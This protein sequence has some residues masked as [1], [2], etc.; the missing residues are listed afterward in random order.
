MIRYTLKYAQRRQII[1]VCTCLDVAWSV[2]PSCGCVG[3]ALICITDT[4][5][6]ACTQALHAPLTYHATNKQT[7]H[8]QTCTAGYDRRCDMHP[9]TL[10][11]NNKRSDTMSTASKHD[12]STKSSII[13]QPNECK[14]TPGPQTLRWSDKRSTRHRRDC[15]NWE[16]YT[17]PLALLRYSR[18]KLA[19]TLQYTVQ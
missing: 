11:Y 6:H 18:K 9:Q 17:L 3:L 15:P 12:V 7:T 4:T 16:G 2:C 8:K 13:S 19:F 14:N 10:C 5:M 1:Y